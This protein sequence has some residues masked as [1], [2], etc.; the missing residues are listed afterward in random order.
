MVS[1]WRPA[2]RGLVCL[3]VRLSLPHT[4]T[5]CLG[6]GTEPEESKKVP[7]FLSLHSS[8]ERQRII[9]GEKNERC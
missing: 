6:P 7:V 2:A 9:T 4:S 5:V 3:S 8:E 1:E